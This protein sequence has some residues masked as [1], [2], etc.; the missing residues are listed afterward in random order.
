LVNGVEIASPIIHGFIRNIVSPSQ[1]QAEPFERWL[2]LSKPPLFET[3][4]EPVEASR[5]PKPV[6]CRN[7]PPTRWLSLSKS[8]ICRSQPSIETGKEIQTL[9]PN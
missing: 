1:A 2:S 4:A 6:I 9:L 8:V 7:R 3:L 5:L